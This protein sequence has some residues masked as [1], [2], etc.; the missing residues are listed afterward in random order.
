MAVAVGKLRI[1]VLIVSLAGYDLFDHLS[2]VGQERVLPFVHEDSCRRVQRR[3]LNVTVL[4]P[5]RLRKSTNFPAQ[6]DE[7]R[8]LVCLYRD[9]FRINLGNPLIGITVHSRSTAPRGLY[10]FH[11]LS[12]S[13]NRQCLAQSVASQT[14]VGKPGRG[15][16][17]D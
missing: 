10:S 9:R 6:V 5:G 12:P 17:T 11:S 15:R 14:G 4:D 2:D 16:M 13:K 1:V 8:T 3:D 7:L